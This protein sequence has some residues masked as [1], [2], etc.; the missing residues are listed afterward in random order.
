MVMVVLLQQPRMKTAMNRLR[1][2]MMTLAIMLEMMQMIV[3][4]NTAERSGTA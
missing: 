2:K 3:S 4:M 1:P